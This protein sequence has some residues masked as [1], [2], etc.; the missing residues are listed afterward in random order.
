MGQLTRF[1]DYDQLEL[2]NN[3]AENAIRPVAV[4]RNYGN[5]RIM[6]SSAFAGH[7]FD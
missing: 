5:S 2:S 4:G 1:L 7:D 6:R 3:L